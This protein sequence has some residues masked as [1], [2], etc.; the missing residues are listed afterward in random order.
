MNIIGNTI[1]ITGG[2]SGIG[3]G[4]AQRLHE[5]G[6]RVIVAGRRTALL[7]AITAENPGITGLELDVADPASIERARETVAVSHPELNV[8]INNAGIMREENVLDVADVRT[9]EEQVAIN[10]LGTVRMVYAFAPALVGKPDAA[11][12]NVSSSLAF[13]PF[14][15]TPTYSATKAAL[16]SFSESLRVQLSKAETGIQVIEIVPPGVRT[17]LMDQQESEHAMPLEDYLTEVMG[18]LADNPHA[19]EVVVERALPMRR[20]ALDGSYNDM[21]TMFSNM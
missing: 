17:E 6:N 2:T 19:D 12:V 20:A 5:S 16:H 10:L 8:V 1:L 4:L 13:V 15:S 7:D 18:L 11:I 3:L 21:L 14:P 9:A